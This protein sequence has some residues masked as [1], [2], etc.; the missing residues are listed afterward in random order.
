MDN[1]VFLK[2]DVDELSDVSQKEEITAMPTF[3]LYKRGKRIDSLVGASQE[4]LK[5]KIDHGVD[6]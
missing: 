5:T 6:A 1:V 4:Q 2:V 3:Y